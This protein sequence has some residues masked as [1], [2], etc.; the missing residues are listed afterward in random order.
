M[1]EIILA[2]NKGIALVDNED[3]EWL[4]QY[5]WS[6][7]AYGY[8]ITNVRINKQRKSKKMHRLIMNEPI[9]FEIDHTDQNGLNNQ[10]DNLRISTHSQNNMNRLKRNGCSSKYKG[11]HF[12]KSI[13]KWAAN[14]G[15]NKKQ[16]YLGYFNNEIDA[17][18]AYNKK[19]KELHGKYANLNEV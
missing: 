5:K 8:A 4:N 10:K 1:K 12:K 15:F 19:A 11:V 6:L 3:Y 14:I 7:D 17:A 13:D 2:N 16:I 18:N 9:G